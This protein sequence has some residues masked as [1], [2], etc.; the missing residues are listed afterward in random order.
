MGG[1]RWRTLPL[2]SPFGWKDVA[3]TTTRHDKHKL[4][5]VYVNIQLFNGTLK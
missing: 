4:V 1:T 5:G 2:L 3:Y